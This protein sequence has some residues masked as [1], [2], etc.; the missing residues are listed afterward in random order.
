MCLYVFIELFIRSVCVLDVCV[1]C[2]LTPLGPVLKVSVTE[3]KDTMEGGTMGS[4]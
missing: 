1:N 3:M 4:L 2:G